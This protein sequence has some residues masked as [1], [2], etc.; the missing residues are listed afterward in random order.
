MGAR[1]RAEA[2]RGSNFLAFLVMRL[3]MGLQRRPGAYAEPVPPLRRGFVSRQMAD[4]RASLQVS[5][6]FPDGNAQQLVGFMGSG[7]LR[8]G[9]HVCHEHLVDGGF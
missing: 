4:G 9:N 8:I 5:E 7:Q 1:A 3:H 2:G 6:V